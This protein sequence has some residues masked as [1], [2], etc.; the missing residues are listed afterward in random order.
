M[1]IDKLINKYKDEVNYLNSIVRTPFGDDSLRACEV[2]LKE[3]QSI[4]NWVDCKI[5]KPKEGVHVLV[6]GGVAYYCGSFSGRDEWRSACNNY[7]IEWNVTHWMP[8]PKINP[9]NQGA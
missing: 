6:D 5:E 2:F 4:N 9:K 1:D 7:I 8:L 3:L